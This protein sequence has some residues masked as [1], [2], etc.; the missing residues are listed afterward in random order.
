MTS[1]RKPTKEEFRRSM[2]EVGPTKAGSGDSPYTQEW[3]D[4]MWGKKSKEKD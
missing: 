4:R 1:Y 3:M 2:K